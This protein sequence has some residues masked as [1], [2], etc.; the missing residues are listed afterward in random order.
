MFHSQNILPSLVAQ[1]GLLLGDTTKA[2]L[3]VDRI[4]SYWPKIDMSAQ[5]HGRSEEH[6]NNGPYG[7]LHRTALPPAPSAVSANE[8][9]TTSEYV[10]QGE[11]DRNGR[12]KR[13]RISPQQLE[14]LL[15]LFQ[16]TDT[17]S[18]EQRERVAARLGMSNREV[19]VC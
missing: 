11:Q 10:V 3:F 4:Q 14:A 17:P 16:Q 6:A 1:E 7:I 5:S 2:T 12:P 15:E 13:K 18:Y 8:D 9:S 19:Q